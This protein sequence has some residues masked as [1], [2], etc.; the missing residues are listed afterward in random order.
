MAHPAVSQVVVFAVKHDKLGEDVAAAVV[1]K[2]G[3]TATEQEIRDF[4][5]KAL[6]AYRTPRKVLFLE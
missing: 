6:A 2:E 5:A 3:A 4:A 1:L